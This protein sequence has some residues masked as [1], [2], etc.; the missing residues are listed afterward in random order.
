[1]KASHPTPVKVVSP[2]QA[3]CLAADACGAANR[4]AA[5]VVEA[6]AALVLVRG[7]DLLDAAYPT[8]E[9]QEAE[10]HLQTCVAAATAT[11]E[12]ATAAIKLA[13]EAVAQAQDKARCR[14]PPPSTPQQLGEQCTLAL[15]V[16]EGAQS[17]VEEAREAAQGGPTTDE[18]L[19]ATAALATAV[20]TLEALGNAA[21][22][23]ALLLPAGN[24]LVRVARAGLEGALLAS[25]DPWLALLH[26][27]APLTSSPSGGA[28]FVQ[29]RR[30]HRR[31]RRSN[32]DN[33]RRHLI[34]QHRLSQ[35]QSRRRSLPRRPGPT[36]TSS[37]SSHPSIVPPVGPPRFRPAII[38]TAINT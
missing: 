5:A 23:A 20:H 16:L 25:F 35:K 9:V 10:G 18:H 6:K 13:K 24:T 30:Y 15:A 33:H 32:F 26:R 1:L 19:V 28:P 17:A 34:R 31:F 7:E 11:Y 21:F 37:S 14:K 3:R 36:S 29:R 27:S 12:L 38:T 22:A 2:E 4:A 8:L